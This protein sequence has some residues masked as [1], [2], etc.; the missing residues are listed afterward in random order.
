MPHATCTCTCTCTSTCVHACVLQA[1]IGAIAGIVAATS[2][3]P[4][5]VVRRRQMGGE[6][7]SLS[8]IGAMCAQRAQRCLSSQQ[9]MRPPATP[10]AHPPARGGPL[11]PGAAPSPLRHRRGAAAAPAR[12]KS[13]GFHWASATHARLVC[14]LYALYSPTNYTHST[15]YGRP[16]EAAFRHRFLGR[17]AHSFVIG[18]PGHARAFVSFTLVPLRTRTQ[19]VLQVSRAPGGTCTC[20]TCTCRLPHTRCAYAVLV[21]CMCTACALHVRC[22]CICPPAAGAAARLCLG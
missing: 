15:Y 11:R 21:P 20:G 22:I 9:P 5:E 12:P 14:S 19:P 4:F 7:T 8:V 18:A 13:P 16:G 2:C 10:K 3:F 17:A 1:Q 6:L